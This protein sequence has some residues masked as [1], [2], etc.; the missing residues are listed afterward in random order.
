MNTILILLLIALT[1]ILRVS[2][3]F[4]RKDVYLIDHFF[5]LLYARKI[6]RNKFRYPKYFEN[7]IIKK[8]PLAYPFLFHYFLALFPVTWREN[9]SYYLSGLIDS[10]QVLLL[11][12]F[13][14]YFLPSINIELP[15]Y[16][17]YLACLT[18]ATYPILMRVGDERNAAASARPLGE[19]FFLFSILST[20]LYLLHSSFI[21]FILAILFGSFVLLT[22]KFGAQAFYFV[23]F[24]CSL[25]FL[26]LVFILITASSF[27]LAVVISYGGYLRVFRG[28]IAH[29]FMHN[30]IGFFKGR[31]KTGILELLNLFIKRPGEAVEAVYKLPGVS[32]FIFSPF[33]ILI[34][35]FYL[36]D[37]SIIQANLFLK[38]YFS[39]TIATVILVFFT[40]FGKARCFGEAERYADYSVFAISLIV[41]LFIYLYHNEIHMWIIFIVILLCH[42]ILYGIYL[43][44]WL[45]VFPSGAYNSQVCK[46]LNEFAPT[47][48]A[49]IPVNM[50]YEL[51][52]KTQHKLLW[53]PPGFS[54]NVKNFKK[55]ID[56]FN[57]L[58]SNYPL[59]NKDLSLLIEEYNIEIIV[60]KKL[61]G[62]RS[63]MNKLD[64]INFY[65]TS[66]FTQIYENA[67]YI[68]YRA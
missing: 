61:Y 19:L 56:R 7:F 24:I 10:I 46:K 54:Q 16:V 62:F 4:M 41:P 43:Y 55:D 26:D 37:F 17:I 68:I 48:V 45:K 57:K 33:L 22:S 5:H 51:A 6:R 35:Y 67:E 58:Y 2:P 27:L 18:F 15:A 11:G 32:I 13:M 60:M 9:A 39:W 47:N 44:V 34:I 25:F 23:F 64:I 65:D 53:D 36:H 66:K 28:H 52:Y 20:S 31:K 59:L 21:F 3:S 12:L 14:F 30:K 50:S 1:F 42:L 49:C 63:I 8:D 29:S 38:F 40:S